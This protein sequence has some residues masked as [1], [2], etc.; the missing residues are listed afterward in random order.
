MSESN[1]QFE[2][3]EPTSGALDKKLSR[4]AL[5]RAGLKTAPVVAA[6]K[7]DMVMAGVTNGTV[8]RPSA[9]SSFVANG[10]RCS[11]KPAGTVTHTGKCLTHTQC[12]QL[13][14]TTTCSFS[15]K[16]HC[17]TEGTTGCGFV[18]P[19]TYLSGCTTNNPKLSWIVG[20]STLTYFTPKT[21]LD[22]LALY[23]A[24]GY[25]SA[26]YYGDVDCFITAQ[27]CRDLWTNKGVW[28]VCGVQ[29]DLAWTLAYFNN[30]FGTGSFDA[31]LSA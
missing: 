7:T 31:C 27:Q 5:V 12:K 4:R 28:T 24:L 13:V 1:Q 20:T 2:G 11:V 17:N 30:C 3:Q 16:Y 9:F 26:K 6:L 23:C 21:D 15:T 29:R 19:T 10:Q 14:T 8:V 25:M 22:K 18:K